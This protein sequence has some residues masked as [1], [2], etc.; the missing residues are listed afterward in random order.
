[1]QWARIR[2]ES[3]DVR[4]GIIQ[5]D[6]LHPRAALGSDESTGDPIAL[7]TTTLLPPCVPGKFIGLW[8]NFKAA[9]ERNGWD[10]PDHPLYF[11]KPLSSLA[12][13]GATVTL[14]PDLGRVLF[15]GELGI[16]IGK[17][18]SNIGPAEAED[19]IFGYTCV[20]D[21]TAL[22]ILNADPSFPQWTRAKGFDGFGV[23]GPVIET[24]VHWANLTVKVM[25]G[26]RERQ[27]YPAN[28][29]IFTPAEIVSKLSADMTLLP[30]DV[31]ACGTSIGAR[32]IKAGQEVTVVIDGI[33]NL[34][35]TIID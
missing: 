11:L 5:G 7:S 29:M 30:G 33:G 6:M 3:G 4:T 14:P 27:S 10:T 22:D 31:I 21:I 9:A 26:E 13:P 1:M 19:A 32:P 17:S 25:V 23:I 12:G 2:T 28:D 8:N 18:C 20:N 35:V 15:E 34:P 24:D 16:V